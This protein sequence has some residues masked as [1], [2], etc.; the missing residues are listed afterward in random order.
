MNFMIMRR[1]KQFHS[2]TVEHSLVYQSFQQLVPCNLVEISIIYL[3]S[4]HFVCP[5]RTL[6]VDNFPLVAPVTN[7]DSITQIKIY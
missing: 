1:I 6:D 2:V 5:Q 3:H 7:T 4:I